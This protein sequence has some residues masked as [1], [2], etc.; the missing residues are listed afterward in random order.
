MKG[1]EPLVIAKLIKKSIE[2]KHPKTRYVGG[3]MA[4]PMLLMRKLL[5]D[6]LFDKLI[7]SQMN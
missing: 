1:S 4:K 3:A 6:K 7:M 5:S 2:A